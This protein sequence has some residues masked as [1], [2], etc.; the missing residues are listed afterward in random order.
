ML[1][2]DEFVRI[3]GGHGGH[4][5]LCGWALGAAEAPKAARADQQGGGV[6]LE[7]VEAAQ[8]LVDDREW[9]EFLGLEH[10]LVEPCLDFV[11]LHFRQL[12]V[13]IVNVSVQL[14]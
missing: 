1:A 5:A 6:G 13:G 4:I 12:L 7:D 8:F 2:G 10:L 11:L 9:L 3:D 14:Q